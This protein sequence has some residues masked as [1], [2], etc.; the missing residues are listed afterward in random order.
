M[1]D[2]TRAL[3][4]ALFHFIWQG[5]A[6]AVALWIALLLLRKKS[7]N[8][9]YV[10][11]FVALALMAALPLLTASLS[12]SRAV[13]TAVSAVRAQGTTSSSVN[14]RSL[15]S[16]NETSW[17]VQ[18]QQWALTVWSIGVVLFSLRIV[19]S[20]RYLYV[21]KRRGAMAEAAITELVSKLGRRMGVEKHVRVLISSIAESPGAIGWLR[22][23]ILLP[24]SSVLG[25]SPEQ[26]EAVIAHELAHI[27][28]YDYLVSAFQVVVET[29]LFYHPAVWWTSSRIRAEREFCCDDL[30]VRACGDAVCYA[31][32]LSSLEKM[33][34][35]RPS[36]VLGVTDG[37]LLYRI[38][39]I[40]GEKT[41]GYGPSK[42]SVVFVMGFAVAG[43]T[44][45]MGWLGAQP[46]KQESGTAGFLRQVGPAAPDV[47]GVNVDLGGS[48]LLHRTSVGYPESL[49]KKGID[50]T[51]SVEATL[52]SSG[53]VVDAHVLSGP[54]ELR[55]SALESVL[56]W[57]FVA[58]GAQSNR[59]VH[60][61]FDSKAAQSARENGQAGYAL[62]VQKM[63]VTPPVLSEEQ[64]AKL[65][66]AKQGQDAAAASAD[67]AKIEPAMMKLKAAQEE[68]ELRKKAMLSS[69]PR[70]LEPG[71]ARGRVLA[72]IS[73]IGL[74]DQARD[75]LLGKL[76]VRVGD[77]LTSELL[78]RITAA[79]R[80]F[81]EH[82]VNR[83]VPL[84]NNGAN[85]Q[86]VAPS[87]G[88][89]FVQ[90]RVIP[91]NT[92]EPTLRRP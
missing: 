52:D 59:T 19:W 5:A 27:R 83:Y 46:K 67:Q 86:I 33:R 40:I 51:V 14:S 9:R 43:L 55:R 20:C 48:S 50:G 76:P 57:H 31:R 72:S 25:L 13:T 82:L 11:S 1:N 60:I 18:A 65:A 29:L 22:P 2:M 79:V 54:T 56:Q 28:R 21:L 70:K 45:N 73:V 58:D 75:Q 68:Q 47:P 77:T 36:L 10:V 30:A 78:E 91:S 12:Y 23:I 84:E 8:T 37:S 89:P 41:M 49:W 3:S 39:R 15:V 35:V 62:T 80:G 4:S 71:A 74:S 92:P 66:K 32:A 16:T 81:D 64:A 17:L 61:M 42:L 85:L 34:A 63:T 53:N 6:V 7:P 38:Q 26:L 24:A 87:G 44:I 88:E 69:E 90:F